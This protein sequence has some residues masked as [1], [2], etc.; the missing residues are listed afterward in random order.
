M[1]DFTRIVSTLLKRLYKREA[2]KAGRLT[3]GELGVLEMLNELLISPPVL[4]LQ[5]S[6]EEVYF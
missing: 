5:K 3:E 1:P 2:M 6:N 4:T